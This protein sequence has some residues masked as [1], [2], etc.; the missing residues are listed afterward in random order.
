MRYVSRVLLVVASTIGVMTS[1]AFAQNPQTLPAPSGQYV[2]VM[3]TNNNRTVIGYA[4]NFSTP[5][6][7]MGLVWKQDQLSE[8]AVSGFTSSFGYS[9]NNSDVIVGV[10]VNADDKGPRPVVWIDETGTLLPTLGD[11][12]FAYDINDD[13]T[14]VGSVDDPMTGTRAAVWTDGRLSVLQSPGALSAEAKAIDDDGVIYGQAYMLESNG[15]VPVRWENGIMSTL[16]MNFGPDYLG[17][18]GIRDARA[19]VVTGYAI[20]RETL[21]DGTSY[22]VQVAI[23]WENGQFRMLERPSGI[24]NSRAF[25]V[26]R[27]GQFVGSVENEIGETMPVIWTKEGPNLLPSAPGS[28]MIAIARNDFGYVV[29]IDYSNPHA[30]VPIAWDIGQ[31]VSIAMLDMTV[32]A[33][34]TVSLRANATKMSK[35]QAGQL[36][37]FSV[38]GQAV[39]KAKT[40]SSGSVVIGY[41]VPPGSR[42]ALNVT[43]SKSGSAIAMRS[44]IVGKSP[45]I[46]GV[47]PVIGRTGQRVNLTANLRLGIQNT[48]LS[49]KTISFVI[50]GAL[51]AQARTDGF[52][53]ARTSIVMAPSA[54][55]ASMQIEARY[56]GDARTTASIGRV[57]GYLLQ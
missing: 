1:G 45:T 20:Q 6:G 21:P 23:A 14:I 10:A 31:E 12:G 54:T 32:A 8:L 34:Q 51:V 19:G 35:P 3:A 30:P 4:L 27:D 37:T 41:K 44:L 33:G 18:V 36:I 9:L 40:N 15:S 28:S 16:P 38:N 50:N 52:G 56:D 5:G 39:G 55:G 26:S 22:V 46:V 17:V 2:G 53:V 47:T 57:S 11:R 7:Y 48:P 49:R 25:N 42:G 13:G 24:G 43:A 29:G